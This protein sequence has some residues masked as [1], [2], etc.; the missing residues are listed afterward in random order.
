MTELYNT[1]M[2]EMCKVDKALM[3]TKLTLARLNPTEFVTSIIKRSGY[4]A[5]VAGEVLHIL[6]CKP[7]YV[8]PRS[9]DTCYQEIPVNYNNQTMFIAP[10]THIL[11]KRGT[12]IDCTTLRQPNSK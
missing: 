4:T 8:T 11:Q 3:E 12:Q 7:V 1:V 2:T 9:D 10:V 6:E 5:V